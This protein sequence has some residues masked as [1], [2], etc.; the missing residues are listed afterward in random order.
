MFF[1]YTQ[2]GEFSIQGCLQLYDRCFQL[3]KFTVCSLHSNESRTIET[4][5]GKAKSGTK[6]R[7][8]VT[9]E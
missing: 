9:Q 1:H 8:L 7:T 2:C 3:F 4:R 5:D 6:A